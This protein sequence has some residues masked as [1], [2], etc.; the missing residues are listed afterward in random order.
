MAQIGAALGRQFS[1]QLITAVATMPQ[2][3]LD[4]ALAQLVS[5]GLIWRRGS[6]PEAEYTFKHAL[7]QDAAY[8]TLLRESRRVL[9]ARI[10][11]ILREPIRGCH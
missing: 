8:G 7:V 5:A 4:D 3:E 1:H 2:Q 6:P 10:A 11:E 9:H